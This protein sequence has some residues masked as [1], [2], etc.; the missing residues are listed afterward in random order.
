MPMPKRARD[1]AGSLAVYA[2]GRMIVMLLLGFSAGLPFLLVFSTLSAWLREAGISRTDIGLMSYVGLAYTIKFLWAPVLDHI[3]LPL[4]DR[5]L[6]KRRAWMVLAQLVAAAALAGLSFS[7]PS[8]SL[9]PVVLFALV[10]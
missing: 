7:D 2:E 4:L 6:G 1:W 9:T 10:L 5:L 3:R 8:T